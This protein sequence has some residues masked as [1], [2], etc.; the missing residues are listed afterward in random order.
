MTTQPII[1]LT[2]STVEDQHYAA[3]L[4]Y[5]LYSYALGPSFTPL[6]PN[7]SDDTSRGEVILNDMWGGRW[8]F[9]MTLHTYSY[10][11]FV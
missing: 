2:T 3:A 10:C 9:Q 11:A 1:K 4:E 7:D 8:N 5:F 6:A